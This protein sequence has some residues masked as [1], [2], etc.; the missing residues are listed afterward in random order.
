M[1]VGV[2]SISSQ[3]NTRLKNGTA[4]TRQDHS[5]YV[6]ELEMFHQLHCLVTL[7][8]AIS[9]NNSKLSQ[10]W[11]RDQSWEFYSSS[12]SGIAPVFEP[13]QSN[14]TGELHLFTAA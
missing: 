13:Q 7:P 3:E 2:V 1:T 12:I 6:V 11:L 14:H 5:E 9:T 10:K 8:F 4:F